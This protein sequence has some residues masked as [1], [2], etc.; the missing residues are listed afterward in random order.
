MFL[1]ETLA[2]DHLTMAGVVIIPGSSASTCPSA[3]ELEN[4]QQRINS[5][6]K[7]SLAN[8]VVPECG[9]GLWYRIAHLNMTDSSQ[10]CPSAWREYNTDGVRACGRLESAVPS[11]SDM[12]FGPAERRPEYRK[13][14]G[15]IIGY[16]FGNPDGFYPSNQGY[17]DGITVRYGT[18]HDHIWSYVAGTSEQINFA[19]IGNCRCSGGTVETRF[20]GD[21]YYCESANPNAAYIEARLHL[22]D[23]LWDGQ[24]CDNEGTCC[25]GT[26]TP[27]WFSVD[28][29]PST[30]VIEVRI[31]GSETTDDEDTPIELLELYVQ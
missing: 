1:A 12:T 26:N 4:A 9:D 14:C 7:E 3:E 16:Q 27:P 28:L 22:N 24:Q 25:T 19:R 13:V 8:H 21:N 5:V 29:D 15:R 6:V 23:K 31:C 30:D 11:C 20:I 2:E 18:S 17:I 10:Q